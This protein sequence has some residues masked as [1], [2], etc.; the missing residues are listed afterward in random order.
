MAQTYA[1]AKAIVEIER[2]VAPA[3]VT[4]RDDDEGGAWVTVEDMPLGGPWAEPTT[5]IGFRI[6]YTYP[7]SDVYPHFVRRDLTR[8]DGA[9]PMGEAMSH[10]AYEG[11]EAIQISRASNKRDPARETAALKLQKV[12][13]WLRSRP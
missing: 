7:Y 9:A 1:V 12:L 3:R 6:T 11:R 5:W 10:A 8:T 13:T 4:V 2:C